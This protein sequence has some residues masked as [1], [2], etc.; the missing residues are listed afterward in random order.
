MKQIL[1]AINTRAPSEQAFRYAVDLSR[2]I[3]AGLSI[4][5]FMDKGTLWEHFSVSREKAA[6][7]GRFLEDAFAQVAFAEEGVRPEV[8]RDA[9]PLR[10]ILSG[11][12]PAPAPDI[13]EGHGDPDADLRQFVD[14]HHDV[15]VTILDEGVLEETADGGSPGRN[16]ARIEKLK[17]K[18]GVPLVVV[19]PCHPSK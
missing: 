2:R 11:D 12:T 10:R 13:S 15:V 17:K 6:G 5:R 4:L 1:L 19:K 18:L 8:S 3:R 16:R 14:D 7:L 9:D